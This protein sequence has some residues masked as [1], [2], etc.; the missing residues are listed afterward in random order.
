[1]FLAFS[2]IFGNFFFRGSCTLV[3]KGSDSERISQL[4]FG[5]TIAKF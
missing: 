4:K 5:D 1:M 3:L 2:V